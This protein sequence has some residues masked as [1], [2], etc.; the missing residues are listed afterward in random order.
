M[1]GHESTKFLGVFVAILLCAVGLDAQSPDV[2]RVLQ[3]IRTADT[4][5]LSVSRGPAAQ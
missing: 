4:G 2:E 5:R 1:N 3:Q